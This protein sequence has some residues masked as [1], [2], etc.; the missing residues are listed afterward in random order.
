MAFAR[1][2][3]LQDSECEA[4]GASRASGCWDTHAQPPIFLF[5]GLGVLGF[6]A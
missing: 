4:Y 2:L 3:G 1:T 6:R 5:R